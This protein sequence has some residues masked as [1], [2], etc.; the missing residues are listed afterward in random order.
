MN[1]A[2]LFGSTGVTLGAFGAHLLKTTL[3]ARNSTAS[4][5]TAVNYQLLHA[6]AILALS[7]AS[8]TTTTDS[9]DPPQ[10]L[11]HHHQFV[12]GWHRFIFRLHLR[13]FIGWPKN[14][15]TSDTARRLTFNRWLV[16]VVETVNKSKY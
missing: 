9:K 11:Q 2:A 15:R 4:W 8:T 5:K 16:G 14:P 10:K 3:E 12:D 6:V 7:T 1:R 13:T